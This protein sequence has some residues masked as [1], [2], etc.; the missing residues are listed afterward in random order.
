[1]A[2]RLADIAR[3]LGAEVLGDGT[4]EIDRVAEPAEAGPRDIAMAIEP[5]F[6]RDLPI[7]RARAALVWP[8][9]DWQALGLLGAIEVKRAAAALIGTTR[10]L[11]TGPGIPAGIHPSAVIDPQAVIGAGAAIGPLAVIGR[12][13]VIGAHAR[14]GAHVSV[15]EGVRIGDDALLHPGVKIGTGTVIGDRFIANLNAAIGGDGFAY[16]TMDEA[17]M[18][19]RARAA[20]GAGGRDEVTGAATWQRVYSLGGVEI[21]DDVEIGAG[22]TIDKG[23]LRA[24]R[25]GRGT[26]IDSQVHIGHNCEIGEDCLIAGAVGIAGSVQIGNRVVLGGQVGVSDHVRIG[27]DVIA[28]GRSAIYTDVPG[29]RMVW[30]DPAVKIETQ[31]AIYKEIRRLP[32]LARSLREL[33]KAVSKRAGND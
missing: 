33:Q 24:T 10:L 6:A 18:V 20:I 27:D 25:I 32:R 14:I 30:G 22:S 28:G 29:G 17:S 8:G 23:T 4:I 13:A 5:R 19:E 3:A 31:M 2:V 26:K 1:M 11:D 15:G 7:G 9:A 16:K 12:G 21:G